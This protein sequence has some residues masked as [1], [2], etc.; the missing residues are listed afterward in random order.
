[1]PLDPELADFLELIEL[2]RL[3]G[4]QRP[5]H[6]LSVAEARAAF[7]RTTAIFEGGPEPVAATQELR[8]PTRDGADI[9]ARLYRPKAL[10][11]SPLP[12]LLFLHGG[13]YV[14]GD[15]D[16]HDGVCRDLAHRSGWAVLSPDYRLAP[17]HKF[18]T[19]LSDS[20]DAVQWLATQGA[21]HG[22][23]IHC[24]SVA[25]DSV[26]GSMAAVLAILAAHEPEKMP[27][28]LLQQILIYPVTDA[29]VRYPSHQR[30][31]IGH[32]LETAS[33]DWFYGHYQSDMAERYD[34]RFSPLRAPD[35]TALAP[36]FIILAEFDPLLDE[37]L[38]YARRL[39]ESAVPVEVEVRGG[40]IHDFLRMRALTPEAI[41]SREKVADILVRSRSLSGLPNF[42]PP[43]SIHADRL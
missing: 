9:A 21:A 20:L 22:L 7:A 32:L 27:L 3:G 42:P 2:G 31:G 11:D 41:R 13:G 25:G 35:L 29:A 17:E 24:F 19:A 12:V 40:M 5:I 14:L 26:G 18:P 39:Q 4:K 15:L 34:W 23:D 38:A 10:A 30:F 1:M 33:L 6:E 43:E 16:S 37:G 36:A 28:A 8:L